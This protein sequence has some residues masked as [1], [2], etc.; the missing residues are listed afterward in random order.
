MN[1]ET[2]Y[3][4]LSI[5]GCGVLFF[6]GI[7]GV[8]LPVAAFWRLAVVQVARSGRRAEHLLREASEKDR[9]GALQGQEQILVETPEPRVHG[10]G[11]RGHRILL[12][13]RFPTQRS[14]ITSTNSPSGA[15]GPTTDPKR[16]R[17][18]PRTWRRWNTRGCFRRARRDGIRVPFRPVR[19]GLVGPALIAFGVVYG[20]LAGLQRPRPCKTCGRPMP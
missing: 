5:V 20:A 1:M 7:G 4:C 15:Y 17:R 11:K 19:L 14:A 12:G 2:V 9:L 13:M 8:A 16:L 18:C 6:L 10:Q 3:A